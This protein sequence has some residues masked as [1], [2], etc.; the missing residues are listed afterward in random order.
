MGSKVI[1]VIDDLDRVD[2]KYVP[3]ILVWL[4]RISTIKKGI[5]NIIIVADPSKLGQGIQSSFTQ[6][7]QE[8]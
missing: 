1:V 6:Y 5:V 7:S 2:A 4:N 3:E 8:E